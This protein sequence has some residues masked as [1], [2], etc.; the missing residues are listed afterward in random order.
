MDEDWLLPCWAI[1]TSLP[2]LEADKI[3]DPSIYLVELDDLKD[4]GG[5]PEF[6][7]CAKRLSEIKNIDDAFIVFLS[8]TWI[9][10]P[11]KMKSRR[12]ERQPEKEKSDTEKYAGMFE[13]EVDESSEEE[14]EERPSTPDACTKE[15]TIV[16]TLSGDKY[17]LYTE[18]LERMKEE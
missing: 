13:G 15:Y 11:K 9:S 4:H 2:K 6:P 16:D 3:K 18:A 10:I 8:H 7:K 12:L 14:V 5:F 17:R 1:D